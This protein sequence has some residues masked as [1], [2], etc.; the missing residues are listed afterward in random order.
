VEI[1]G[2]TAGQLKVDQAPLWMARGYRL[3][4]SVG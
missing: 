3:R 4:R 2:T 1:P